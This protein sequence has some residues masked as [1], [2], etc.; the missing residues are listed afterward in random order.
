MTNTK[1][2]LRRRMQDIRHD[3]ELAFEGELKNADGNL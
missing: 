2:E 3:L 1:E